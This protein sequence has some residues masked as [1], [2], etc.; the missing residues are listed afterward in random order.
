MKYRELKLQL[1]FHALFILYT[2]TSVNN[3]LALQFIILLKSRLLFLSYSITTVYFRLLLRVITASNALF[4][5]CLRFLHSKMPSTLHVICNFVRF[6]IWPL[7][8][9]RLSHFPAKEFFCSI[10]LK[11]IIYEIRVGKREL[12]K[13][14]RVTG[15]RGTFFGLNISKN[16]WQK[17][18]AVFCLPR[19]TG[20]IRNKINELADVIQRKSSRVILAHCIYWYH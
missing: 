16:R 4:K 2:Y 17:V 8:E 5:L 19:T 15:T 10:V 6:A 13:I 1:K 3:N 20:C 9:W 14:D 11:A 18:V 7:G 12:F